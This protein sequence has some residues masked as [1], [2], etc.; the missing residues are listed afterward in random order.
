MTPYEERDAQTAAMIRR[1]ISRLKNDQLRFGW[2]PGSGAW[3]RA[4]GK[5]SGFYTILA[6]ID[7]A[8]MPREQDL[9]DQLLLESDTHS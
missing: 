8:P 4:F 3:N 1:E 6:L 2:T 7:P 5:L 9:A